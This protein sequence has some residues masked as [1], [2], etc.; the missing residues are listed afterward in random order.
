[1]KKLSV[2][3][4]LLMVVIVAVGCSPGNS[5]NENIRNMGF[6]SLTVVPDGFSYS[7][8]KSIDTGDWCEISYENGEGG[9]ISFD[10][11]EPDSFDTS[12]I[13]YNSESTDSTSINGKEATI[14]VVNGVDGAKHSMILWK[15]EENNAQC[16]ISGNVSQDEMI[17]AA[18]SAK[19]DMKKAVVAASD[20]Q[21]TSYSEEKDTI[22]EDSLNKYSDVLENY[23]KPLFDV[24]INT[25]KG[26]SKIVLEAFYKSFDFAAADNLT[27]E[28]Y[29]FNY[30]IEGNDQ[31][32]L[33][34]GMYVGK[35][36]NIR[37]FCGSFGQIAV[38]SR[39]GQLIKVTPITGM[40]ILL[41]VDDEEGTKE[42]VE[43]NVMNSV[44][45]P[46]HF[47]ITL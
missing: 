40:D 6:P 4:A 16:I 9:F 37:L 29:N 35:D 28:V 36:G 27:V 25:Q 38:V 43:K 23:T 41:E 33:Y 26:I 5:G 8:A 10:C 44:K 20:S 30:Y 31:I 3:F 14:Y 24:M 13:A 42:F 18:E 34:D 47:L 46:S 1:M 11:Y 39:N 45:I 12:F 21:I 19:Y 17:K 7:D 22:D 2:L 15:D 32:E